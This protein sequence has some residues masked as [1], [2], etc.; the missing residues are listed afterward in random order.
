MS[1]MGGTYAS[2]G[3]FNISPGAIVSAVQ[4]FEP[5]LIGNDH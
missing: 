3:A 5:A 1:W 2:T 4:G